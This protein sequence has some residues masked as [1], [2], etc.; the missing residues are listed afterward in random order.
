MNIFI[1]HFVYFAIIHVFIYYNGKAL[2][3]NGV[4]GCFVTIIPYLNLHKKSILGQFVFLYISSFF[5][6]LKNEEVI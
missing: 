4:N 3:V 5:D 2:C 1:N 6:K